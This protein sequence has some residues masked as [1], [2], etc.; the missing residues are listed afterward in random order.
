MKNYSQSNEQE[1]ILKYFKDFKGT[2]IDIG[3]NDGETL[4]NTRALALNGWCGVLVEPSPKAFRKLKALYEGSKK[5]CFY[6][7]ECALG[8]NNGKTVLHESGALLGVEDVGLVSSLSKEET[9][10]FSRTV[11]YE[12]IEVKV[13]RWKTFL[14]RLY[15]KQFD[16]VSIDIEGLEVEVLEQMDLSEVKLICVETNGNLEKKAKLDSMLQGF[17]VIYTSP[18]NLIYAR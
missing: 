6:I 15:T 4:S 8:V 10:R 14:N 3:A 18:E 12:E 5:G 16:F 7:Y 11:S 1:H 13:F 2:F 17:K 9:K